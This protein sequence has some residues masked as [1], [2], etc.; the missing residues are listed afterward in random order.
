MDLEVVELDNDT[1]DTCINMISS[2]SNQIWFDKFMDLE[3]LK[4]AVKVLN[5][6]K[7]VGFMRFG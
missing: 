6:G 2:H 1:W 7:F 5:T 4:L 3:T